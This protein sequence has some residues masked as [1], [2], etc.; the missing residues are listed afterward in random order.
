MKRLWLSGFILF[1]I[2]VSTL[3]NSWYLNYIISDLEQQLT[4]AHQLASQDNW[5]AAR[6]ITHQAHGHWTQHD[7]YFH[8]VLPHKDIND[9]HL[10]FCEVQEYI[11]LEE[12][13]QYT[14]ANARLIVQLALLAEMDQLNLKNIL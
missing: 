9:I 11:E 1:I 5:N 3:A 12:T 13:N 6:Q 2:L 7:F 4:T 14:A 8:I 10:T